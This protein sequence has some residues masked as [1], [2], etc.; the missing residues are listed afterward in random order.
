MVEALIGQDQRRQ[1]DVQAAMVEGL[2]CPA[3]VEL[4]CEALRSSGRDPNAE[5]ASDAET[6]RSSRLRLSQALS[7]TSQGTVQQRMWA[8]TMNPGLNY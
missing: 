7:N 4:I 2:V 3:L 8:L 6:A 5:T 1:D